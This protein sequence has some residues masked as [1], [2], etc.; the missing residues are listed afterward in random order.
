MHSKQPIARVIHPHQSTITSNLDVSSEVEKRLTRKLDFRL[1]PAL[2]MLC[3]VAF[4]D[5]IAIG[6]AR[7]AG[8]EHAL[9]D[10]TSNQFNVVLSVYWIPYILGQIPSNLLMKRVTPS[11]Y[12]SFLS[13]A[14]G[15]F[16]DH[17][18]LSRNV[19]TNAT[20]CAGIVTVCQ[21]F[22]NSYGSLIACRLCL[23]LFEAGISPGTQY[24]PAASLRMLLCSD[25]CPAQDPSI[26]YRCTIPVG[27]FKRDMP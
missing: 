14:F 26:F 11:V 15:I 8:L 6:N 13:I 25:I 5:K 10:P 24:D 17:V 1:I 21:G 19:S 4:V 9:L 7:I 20:T 18:C 12:L 2:Y 16:K 22:T 23:G 3:L 27:S